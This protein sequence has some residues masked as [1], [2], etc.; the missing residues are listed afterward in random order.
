VEST[1]LNDGLETGII[2]INQEFR[3]WLKSG[4]TRQSGWQGILETFI[5][6]QTSQQFKPWSGK[7]RGSGNKSCKH[8]ILIG[9]D[10][11]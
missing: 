2:V 5:P 11:L 4:Q 9:I 3:G 7:T 1:A 6:G 8:L 10:P